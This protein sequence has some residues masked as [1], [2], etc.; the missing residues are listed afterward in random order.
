MKQT[1]R[2]VS[3]F[4][5]RTHLGEVLDYVRYSK[6][7]CLVERHGT[8]VA[9]IVDIETY[10]EQTRGLQYD[11]WIE[12][13]VER[14]KEN[15][16]PQKIILFGSAAN[17]AVKDGSDIDLFII[18]DTYKRA[19]DRVDEVMELIEPGIP[20]E[21]HI[22]TPKEVEERLKLGDFFIRD[23]IKNGRVLYEQQE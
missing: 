4:E 8:T 21:L 9:A 2:T 6:K 11:K 13:S 3:A 15:Y 18:K 1:S 20:L 23:I 12:L 16:K 19:L 17:G 14:I 10:R 22:F 5:A 7:P